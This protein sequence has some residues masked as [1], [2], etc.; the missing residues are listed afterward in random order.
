MKVKINAA[1][2]T[3]ALKKVQPAVST[4]SI[5]PALDNIKCTVSAGKLIVFATNLNLSIS[6]QLPCDCK[7]DFSFLLPFKDGL[8][9]CSLLNGEIIISI[10]KSISI[11]STVDNFSLGKTEEV[12]VY[13][14]PQEFEELFSMEVDGEF[15]DNLTTSS[16][17]VMPTKS[18][19]DFKEFVCLNA[20]EDKIEIASTNNHKMVVFKHNKNKKK[21]GKYLLDPMFIN[22]ISTLQDG[23]ISLNE[24]FVKFTSEDIIVICTLSEQK[25]TNYKPHFALHEPNCSFDKKE[26]LDVLNNAMAIG[27]DYKGL[28]LSFGNDEIK[29][30]YDDVD[31]SKHYDRVIKATH[32]LELSDIGV[33]AAELK[34]ILT[35]MSNDDTINCFIEAPNKP[36]FMNSAD[37]S[38]DVILM[39]FMLLN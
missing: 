13:P 16:K 32:S 7:E 23:T 33:N 38:T 24:K 1:E 8:R 34:P 19:Y 29:V 27:G 31:V 18:G 9:V 14:N 4:N 26:M 11:K 21:G 15:I 25:Y 22:A 5:I 35:A 17:M 6:T 12:N 30:S 3:K 10:D 36:I 2:F 20:E 39:P 37:G 28:R